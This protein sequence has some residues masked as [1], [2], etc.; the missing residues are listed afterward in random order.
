MDGIFS[1][2]FIKKVIYTRDNFLIEKNGRISWNKAILYISALE[3]QKY[4]EEKFSLWNNEYGINM[5]YIKNISYASQLIDSFNKNS[6]ISTICP[7][8]NIDLYKII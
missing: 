5:Q 8:Y 3:D 4:K 2:E 6:I 7:I 1:F